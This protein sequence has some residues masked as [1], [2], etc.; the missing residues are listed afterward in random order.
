MGRVAWRV[1]VIFRE[2]MDVRVALV[3]CDGKPRYL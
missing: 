2:T 3:D 1:A